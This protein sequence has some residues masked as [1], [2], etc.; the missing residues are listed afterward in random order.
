MQHE[1]KGVGQRGPT[2]GKGEARGGDGNRVRAGVASGRR[3]PSGRLATQTHTR[4]EMARNPETHIH[5][6]D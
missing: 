5:G 2:V 3:E 6:D 4:I 1:S